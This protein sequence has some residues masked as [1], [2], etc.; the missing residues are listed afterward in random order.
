MEKVMGDKSKEEEVEKTKAFNK[1]FQKDKIREKF[2][3]K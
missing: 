2:A 1:Q 3:K